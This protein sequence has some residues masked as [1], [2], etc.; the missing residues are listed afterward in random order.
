MSNGLQVVALFLSLT[1]YKHDGQNFVLS[2][3]PGSHAHM[4]CSYVT[5]ILA[6][7]ALTSGKTKLA[8][9][10]TNAEKIKFFIGKVVSVKIS[11]VF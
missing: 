9:V 8:T 1:I 2:I 4:R 7:K 6:Y 11:Q 10:K 3:K 5:F